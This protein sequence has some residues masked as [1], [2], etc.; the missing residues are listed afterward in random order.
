MKYLI[1]IGAGILALFASGCRKKE[2]PED[3]QARVEADSVQQLQDRASQLLDVDGI[4]YIKDERT[5]LCFAYYFWSVGHNQVL[6]FTMVPCESIPP[7]LL[8]IV[9]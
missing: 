4:Q 5:C 3:V 6:D 1:M 9:K 7:H 2:K 8:T